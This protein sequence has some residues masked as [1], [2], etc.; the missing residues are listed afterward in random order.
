MSI[1]SILEHMVVCAISAH[2]ISVHRVIQNFRIT[3]KD[4]MIREHS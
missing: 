1:R 4:T 3:V 2:T